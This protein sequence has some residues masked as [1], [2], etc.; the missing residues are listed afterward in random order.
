VATDRTRPVTASG[1]WRADW[2]TAA[3]CA[4][5]IGRDLGAGIFWRKV[6]GAP[7]FGVVLGVAQWRVS[8]GVYGA[9]GSVRGSAPRL[10]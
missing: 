9:C 6:P 8:V 1:S 10:V 3:L 5:L 4:A 7:V 2:T